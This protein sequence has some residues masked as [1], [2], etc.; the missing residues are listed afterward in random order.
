MSELRDLLVEELQD[1]LHAENQLVEALP[2]MAA[3]AHNEKLKEAFQKH[4]AQTQGQVERLKQVFEMLGEP[5]EAKPC[6]AMAGLVA[7]GQEKIEEGE[8]KD[9]M[10]ADLSLITAAQKVEHY[11]IAGYGTVRT[12]AHQL[13]EVDAAR[14]L[15]HTLG[16]E[17]SA[18]YLLTEVAKPIVQECLAEEMEQALGD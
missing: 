14:L 5:A 12:L 16:E 11:E 6:K 1:L 7:E 8:D 4:L 15:A 18:D 9:P 3:A 17:E 10:A 2:K 13:G